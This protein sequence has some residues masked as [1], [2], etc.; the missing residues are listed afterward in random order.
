MCDQRHTWA[1][2]F[3]AVRPSTG[4]G[5]ALV[6]PEAST[7]TMQAFLDRFAATLAADE[8]AVMLLDQAGWHG[9]RGLAVPPDITPV[10]PPPCAPELNPVESVW[11]RDR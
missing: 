5:F 11:T 7:R 1:Y 4:Q 9:S 8:H 10:P 2:L 3:A 6:L